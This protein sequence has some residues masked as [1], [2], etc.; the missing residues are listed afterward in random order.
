[1]GI[2]FAGILGI[3]YYILVA[4][5]HFKNEEIACKA[6]TEH[7]IAERELNDYLL[8]DEIIEADCL[9]YE[10]PNSI[11]GLNQSYEDDPVQKRIKSNP[12][13]KELY[14]RERETFVEFLK[15]HP[16]CIKVQKEHLIESLKYLDKNSKL[17]DDIMF[18][19]FLY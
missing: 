8:S 17:S 12:K 15:T 5:P 6:V 2:I 14:V 18:L 4:Y 19:I 10:I 9:I 16:Q 1:M 11:N 13:F 7:C 3:L